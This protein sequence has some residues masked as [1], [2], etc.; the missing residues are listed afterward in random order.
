MRKRVVLFRTDGNSLIGYGHAMRMLALAGI[1]ESDFDI[2]F[3]IKDTIEW[4]ALEI[5]KQYSIIQ[6]PV[7]SNT[8]NETGYITEHI[9]ASSVLIILDG[10]SFDTSYQQRIREKLKMKVISIDDFQP[11]KYVADVVINHAG[12]L[13][14]EQ[15]NKEEY[16]KLLLGP[17]YALLR[18]EF[19][20]IA[21]SNGKEISKAETAF[22]CSGGTWHNIYIQIVKDLIQKGI[23]RLLIVENNF[24]NTIKLK[25]ISRSV[26]LY[27]NLQAKDII[28]LMVQSDFAVLPA[29]TLC[30]EYCSVSGGLFIIQTAEN[31]KFIFD[32]IK[33]TGCGFDYK[34]FD[35]VFDSS[36]LIVKF[37]KQVG[38][39]RE[40][41]DGRNQ[42][43]LQK[44]IFQ[45]AFYDKIELKR[46][47]QKDLMLHY[48]W[49]NDEDTRQNSFNK[50]PIS[51]ETHTL[52]YNSRLRNS[53]SA[54][55]V[56]WADDVP[57]GNI[58]FDFTGAEAV[59]SY[60]IDKNYRGKGLGSILLKEGIRK[61][62]HEYSDI[63]VIN[64]FVQ[65]NNYASMNSFSKAGFKINTDTPSHFENYNYYSL[66]IMR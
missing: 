33:Q 40:Y 36:D 30:Y 12:F 53:A 54:L 29:S 43:V 62:M 52:W 15:F 6:I 1:L 23:K 16:T 24:Q 65:K 64:G 57:F 59:L 3:V 5:E 19:N 39:Q 14:A 48:E 44:E 2:C 32:F 46:A 50:E 58:R 34:D 26:E 21:G 38:K 63:K 66:N 51:L 10:Y 25:S 20:H 42:S 35:S 9:P 45:A 28:D 4:L 22:L 18:R 13:K 11:F 37:N 8:Y 61:V 17:E 60:S 47:T 55:Y 41:F 49:S 7:D 27:S 31:Q 56:L